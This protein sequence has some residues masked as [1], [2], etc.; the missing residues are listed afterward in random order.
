MIPAPLESLSL[1]VFD[2]A[3]LD[4]RVLRDD[5]RDPLLPGNKARK[6]QQNLIAAHKQGAQTLVSMG[7]PYSN[8]LHALAMAGRQFGFATA[9]FV[10]AEPAQPLTPTLADCRAAGMALHFLSR[11][12]FRALRAL[13]APDL[14]C[15]SQPYWLPEGG[16]NA[17]AIPGV[18]AT[19]QTPEVSAFAP[20][21]VLCA[22]GTGATAAGLAAGLAAMQSYAEVWAVAVLKGGS[23]L[24]GDSK[25]LLA[26]AG[27]QKR[28]P[29]RVLTG[30][31]FGGYGRSPETLQRFCRHFTAD[32]GL[33]VEPIYTGRVCYA[34]VALAS[35]G[36]LRHGSR[37]LL[38]HTGGM[39]GAR[40]SLAAV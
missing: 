31:H 37:I 39:Q 14:S 3:G 15:F 35:R 22:A 29:L 12:A 6:L 27:W 24:L 20:D 16:S 7:G 28:Q 26:E 25:R 9:A 4:V 13:P 32:T 1:P 34:L 8:H 38:V 5:Q 17:L 30:Y 10:R 33:P 2:R 19:V 18:A 23:F 36:V 21:L 40:S 11:P